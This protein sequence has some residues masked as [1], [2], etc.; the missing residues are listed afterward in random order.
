MQ[1]KC[2]SI[3]ILVTSKGQIVTTRQLVS[4]IVRL[5]GSSRSA[6]VDVEGG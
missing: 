4:I 3:R 1:E 6:A 5:V 2:T